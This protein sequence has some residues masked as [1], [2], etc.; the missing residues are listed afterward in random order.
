VSNARFPIRKS[1]GTDPDW[2]TFSLLVYGPGTICLAMKFSATGKDWRF[3][4]P[5]LDP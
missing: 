1:I 5:D 3:P 2:Q 4:V